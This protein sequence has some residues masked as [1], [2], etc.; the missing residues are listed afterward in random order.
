MAHDLLTAIALVLIL[1]GLMPGLAPSRWLSM[2]RDIEKLGPRRIR[3]VGIAAM[4]SGAVML[5]FLR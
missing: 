1:E 3:L 5:Q 4:L 2:L